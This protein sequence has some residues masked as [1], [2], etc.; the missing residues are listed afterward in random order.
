MSEISTK[1]VVFDGIDAIAKI[2]LEQQFDV[3]GKWFH[4]AERT[5]DNGGNWSKTRA[6]AGP[7]LFNLAIDDIMRR[8]V[9]L[10]PSDVVI[11]PSGR[12]LT[13]LEYANNVVIFTESSKKLQHVF[14]LVSKLSA[15]K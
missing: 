15:A 5:S 4:P 6:E 14:K 7:F 10:R 3:L 11:A 2:G 1:Q 12:P 9:D 8:T 13:D